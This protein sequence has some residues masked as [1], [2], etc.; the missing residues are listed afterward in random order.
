MAPSYSL[1]FPQRLHS[2]LFFLPF[3]ALP[4]AKWRVQYYTSNRCN[5]NKIVLQMWLI[6]SFGQQSVHHWEKQP[7]CLPEHNLWNVGWMYGKEWRKKRR[8]RKFLCRKGM[9]GKKIIQGEWKTSFYLFCGPALGEDRE[10]CCCDTFY[11]INFLSM[12]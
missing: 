11:R 12:E 5:S 6:I 7:L 10:D 1:F 2:L 3:S 8:R 4:L 9:E